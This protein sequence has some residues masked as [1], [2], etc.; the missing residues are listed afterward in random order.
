MLEPIETNL[1][2]HNGGQSSLPKILVCPP[3]V[4]F[5]VL[6][7]SVHYEK[8]DQVSGDNKQHAL[9]LSCE[10]KNMSPKV[11]HS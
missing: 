8:E 11:K 1:N 3:T 4:S 6:L 5:D 10:K 2:D 9:V 7:V